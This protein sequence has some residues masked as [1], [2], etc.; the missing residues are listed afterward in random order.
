[1]R[2]CAVFAVFCGLLPTA[3]AG[4]PVHGIAMHGAPK[5]G[6]D[7]EHLDYTNPAAPKT[8]VLEEAVVG[9]FDTLNNHI[10]MG[11]MAKGLSL[12]VDPLMQRVWDEPFTLYGLV[13]ETVEIADD[14][15]WIVFNLNPKARFHDGRQMT[16]D[17][18]I[19]SYETY[20][21]HGHPVRRRVYGF[22]DTVEKL[23][24]H[25]VKFSFGEG[26]D[27][28]TALILAIM[29]VLP[30]HYWTDS[31]A[32]RD[33][34]K[35]TLTPPLGSGPYKIIEASPGRQI[36]YERVEDYWAKD[37][38]V[39]RGLYNFDEIRYVYYR[40]SD[41]SLEAFKAGET[42]LRRE[43]DIST[44]TTGYASP[45]RERGEFVQK[46]Y[47]HERPEKVRAFIFNTRRH[48]FRD[49][50]V[51][52]ALSLA[53]HF[54]RMNQMFFDNAFNR[55]E[56]YFPNSELAHRGIADGRELDILSA[57][58][59]ELAEE[60]F[61]PAFSFSPSLTTTERRASLRRA[62]ALLKSAGYEISDQQKLINAKTGKPFNF[63]ILLNSSSDEKIAL[64]YKETLRRLGI[65]ARIR[66]VDNAQFTGR[67]DQFDYDMVL[68]QWVNSLSPGNEQ[69]NYWGSDAAQSMGSR[70]YAGVS[71]PVVDALAM[72]IGA[73]KTRADLVAYTHA[74]DRV[75]M[76]GYYSVPLYY[77]GADMI[78]HDRDLQA[79][80]VTPIYGTVLESWW[81]QER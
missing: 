17:D 73:S 27:Q 80:D 14:R 81:Q 18:V 48:M 8:G 59:D 30:K 72:G 10:I 32:D 16:V 69:M 52:Q 68:Y 76:H 38:P 49:I 45:R 71:S 15:S 29:P 37:L 24:E 22:V 31:E 74:L 34:T 4:E 33:I 65:E 5:Y 36:K 21:N 42:D 39:N 25:S 53:F 77:L 9:S 60:V 66:T 3:L 26:Y 70:N 41:V 57:Y 54:G 64:F 50:R 44:W 6:P 55:I 75:L 23:S 63:E 40:D 61:G 20:R 2:I 19:F 43:Y 11:E 7:F 79:P 67:L 13:A 12:T 58:E 28:E 62:S 35:T 51:R 1:M 47:S 78:A 46:Q 56:S